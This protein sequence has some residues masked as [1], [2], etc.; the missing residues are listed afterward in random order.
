[1][2]ARTPSDSMMVRTFSACLRACV[3]VC[4][5]VCV[6]SCV[7][8]IR[9]PCSRKHG[10]WRFMHARAQTQTHTH[11][12]THV[13]NR[14]FVHRVHSIFFSHARTPGWLNLCEA[15]LDLNAV[16]CALRWDELRWGVGKLGMRV[17]NHRKACDVGR[18]CMRIGFACVHLQISGMGMRMRN[19]RRHRVRSIDR[20]IGLPL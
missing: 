15:A 11:T 3:C 10:P 19:H 8:P 12:R 1:M 2:C 5:Y 18:L 14:M 13:Y 7:N 4:V 20:G 6:C 9:I 16:P 17:G